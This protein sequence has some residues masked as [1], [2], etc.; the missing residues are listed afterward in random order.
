MQWC[1]SV[2]L[3]RFAVKV[4]SACALETALCHVLS[5]HV[6]SRHVCYVLF[7]CGGH[8]LAP[9]SQLQPTQAA[10]LA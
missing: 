10:P 3:L 8:A 4:R 7:L 1:A 6:T 2:L 5:G 9:S